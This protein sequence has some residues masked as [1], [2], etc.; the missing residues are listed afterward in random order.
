MLG[1][2]QRKCNTGC[3]VDGASIA[4]QNPYDVLPRDERAVKIRPARP[5]LLIGRLFTSYE[6]RNRKV[7][8]EKETVY[9]NDGRCDADA[10]VRSRIGIRL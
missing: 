6:R 2:R 1:D 7:G 9:R 8:H 5:T 4:F 3:T 10:G